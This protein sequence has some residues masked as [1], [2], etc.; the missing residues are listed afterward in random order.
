[1]KTSDDLFQLI[2]A[3]TKGEIRFFKL[4]S[5]K[6][7]TKTKNS[8]LQLFEVISKMET[9]DEEA[10]KLEFAGEKWV[11]YL[12]VEKHTLYK[13]LLNAL[14]NYQTYLYRNDP[15]EIDLLQQIQMLQSKS[16]HAQCSKIVNKLRKKAVAK[17]SAIY[18]YL[19]NAWDRDVTHG[20]YDI[21]TEK[22]MNFIIEEQREVIEGFYNT[23]MYQNLCD[24]LYFGFI[25]TKKT[26]SREELEA[27]MAHPML[28]GEDLAIGVTSKFSYYSTYMYYYELINDREGKYQNTL[29][30]IKLLEDYPNFQKRC[31]QNYFILKGQELFATILRNPSQYEAEQK[32]YKKLPEK[33]AFDYDASQT[34]RDIYK[35][36]LLFCEI[37]YACFTGNTAKI[38]ALNTSTLGELKILELKN[39]GFPPTELFHYLAKA[40]FE[41]EAYEQARFWCERIEENLE[42]NPS[43]YI[44]LAISSKLLFLFVLYYKE[45]YNYLKNMVDALKRFLKRK[46]ELN[47]YYLLLLKTIRSNL[48][49]PLSKNSMKTIKAKLPQLT[50]LKPKLYFDEAL[51]YDELE[52]LRKASL[53]L[54][55]NS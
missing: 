52:G 8:S 41:L 12:A 44:R 53:C 34:V 18:H 49:K 22:R 51:F 54:V 32:A 42:K 39:F 3:M 17:N 40:Y 6:Y 48:G 2:K 20:N 13:L 55:E 35:Y 50:Q 29:L 5:R 38:K 4:L 16:L 31:M 14:S 1:M 10:L 21:L 47:E 24:Q 37:V 25:I 15:R 28:Q 33:Y 19:A 30:I 26:R 11:K 45:D 9:Y 43:T 27:F 7:N 23:M 36:Q 46:G